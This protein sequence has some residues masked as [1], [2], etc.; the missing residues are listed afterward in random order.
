V[1]KNEIMKNEKSDEEIMAEGDAHWDALFELT[2]P[3]KEPLDL[4]DSG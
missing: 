4:G 2:W 1:K 3:S